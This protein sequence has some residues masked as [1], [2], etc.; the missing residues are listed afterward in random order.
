MLQE[1]RLE[2]FK[3]GIQCQIGIL[4]IRV[5]WELQEGAVCVSSFCSEPPVVFSHPGPFQGLWGLLNP[6]KPAAHSYPGP[7]VCFRVFQAFS[8]LHQVRVSWALRQR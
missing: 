5:C 8:A 7:G 4:S 1:L 2:Y 3:G 6:E